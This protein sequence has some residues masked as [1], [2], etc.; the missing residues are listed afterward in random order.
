M[1]RY[2]TSSL[3]GDAADP[4][5]SECFSKTGSPFMTP[6]VGGGGGSSNWIAGDACISG[7]GVACWLDFRVVGPVP[8]PW[9]VLW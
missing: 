1:V 9:T 3:A 2:P 5:I 4:S 6:S 7:M 8:P